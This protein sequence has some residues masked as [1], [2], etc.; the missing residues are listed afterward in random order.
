MPETS[1]S[2]FN[3]LTLTVNGITSEI[4][5]NLQ[6]SCLVIFQ[7]GMPGSSL[8]GLCKKHEERIKATV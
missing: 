2:C 8:S 3:F 7:K 5:F 4:D 6:E 1:D